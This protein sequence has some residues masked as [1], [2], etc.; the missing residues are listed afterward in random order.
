MRYGLFPQG[1][2]LVFNRSF[3]EYLSILTKHAPSTLMH[4]AYGTYRQ[5]LAGIP[6]FDKDDPF[7][8]NILSAAM[9]AAVYLNLPEKPQLDAVTVYYRNAM[10]KSR[11]LRIFLRQQDSFSA[12]AQKRLARQAKASQ[13]RRNLYS[14]KFRYEA[15]PD[16][17]SYCTYFDTCGILCLMKKLGIPEIIPALCSYDYDMATLSGSV[18]AREHTL[19]DGGPCCDCHYQKRT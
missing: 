10:T 7:L 15:G 19:A 1:M 5:I 18:L 6:E 9:L 3:Q 12:K 4:K 8:V 16:Q 14:W 13:A 2:W 17:N 11:M